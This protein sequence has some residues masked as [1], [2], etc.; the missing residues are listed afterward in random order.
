LI[1][2]R[3]VLI[4]LEILKLPASALPQRATKI[5]STASPS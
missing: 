4:Q 3:A 1:R 5:D 2:H